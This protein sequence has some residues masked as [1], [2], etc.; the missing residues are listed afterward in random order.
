LWLL[1]YG[2][3][4][5]PANKV[6]DIVSSSL[7][8]DVNQ[9][10]LSIYAM[11]HRSYLGSNLTIEQTLSPGSNYDQYIA[12]YL[13]EGLRIYGLLTVPVVQN[14]RAVGR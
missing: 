11:Q 4:P 6:P 7:V 2:Q 13:S 9:N 12:S 3:K 14:R 5:V 10:P 8:S 1:K